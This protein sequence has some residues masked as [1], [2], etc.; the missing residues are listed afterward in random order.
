MNVSVVVVHTCLFEEPEDPQS[1]PTHEEGGGGD[2]LP[3][4]SRCAHLTECLAETVAVN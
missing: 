3:L 4:T 1:Q 2:G